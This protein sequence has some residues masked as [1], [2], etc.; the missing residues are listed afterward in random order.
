MEV[1]RTLYR[2]VTLLRLI[3]DPAILDANQYAGTVS[4]SVSDSQFRAMT[5]QYR[6]RSLWEDRQWQRRIDLSDA[7]LLQTVDWWCRC[8]AEFPISG[9]VA[10]VLRL[11]SPRCIPDKMVEPGLRESLLAIVDTPANEYR[12]TW[13][14]RP[15]CQQIQ[16]VERLTEIVSNAV[17]A[18]ATGSIHEPMIESVNQELVDQI[19]DQQYVIFHHTETTRRDFGGFYSHG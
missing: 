7:L 2:Q 17:N 5:H 8:D 14:K 10:A 4:L 1:P 15:E 6:T 9:V 16:L 3:G 11:F 13:P 12:T 18:W 19:V